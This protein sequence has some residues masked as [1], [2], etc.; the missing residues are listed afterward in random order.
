MPEI[1]TGTNSYGFATREAVAAWEKLDIPDLGGWGSENNAG[2]YWMPCYATADRPQRPRL[3]TIYH[4]THCGGSAFC[5]FLVPDDPTVATTPSGWLTS[6]LAWIAPLVKLTPLVSH[7]IAVIDDPKAS[8]LWAIPCVDL[9]Y[10]RNQVSMAWPIF[11]DTA[12]TPWNDVIKRF[13]EFRLHTPSAGDRVTTFTDVGAELRAALAEMPTCLDRDVCNN[14]SGPVGHLLDCFYT[15]A[16]ARSYDGW[17][18]Q[19]MPNAITA[20]NAILPTWMSLRWLGG[21]S[22]DLAND[23]PATQAVYPDGTLGTAYLNSGLGSGTSTWKFYPPVYPNSGG[24]AVTALVNKISGLISLDGDNQFNLVM[25]GLQT[26]YATA[27]VSMYEWRLDEG[28]TIVHGLSPSS[29]YGGSPLPS[30]LRAIP[31]G[32][33]ALARIIQP[34]VVHSS[35]LAVQAYTQKWDGVDPLTSSDD[36][37][38]WLELK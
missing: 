1:T 31:G 8:N 18:A 9:R 7:A 5:W 37:L 19:T 13:T 25:A 17:D 6:T 33:G 10:F 34:T 15:L 16:G 23:N 12:L 28:I 20:L 32:G 22:E 11:P 24:T 36:I 38:I 30:G 21:I 29:D 3:N 35:G 2:S 26:P 27:A 14:T 4:P